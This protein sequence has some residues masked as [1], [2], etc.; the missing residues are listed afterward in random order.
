MG[1]DFSSPLCLSFLSGQPDAT[2][3]MPNRSNPFPIAQ[4][5]RGGLPPVLSPPLT[6]YPPGAPP[7]PPPFHAMQFVYRFSSTPLFP[8]FLHQI[9]LLFPPLS[10][11]SP[12]LTPSLLSP[13]TAFCSSHLHPIPTSHNN[14]KKK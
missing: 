8:P 1:S 11:L 13:L 9:P 10:P 12:S 7:L 3:P 6:P 14:F 4:C 2:H 5:L